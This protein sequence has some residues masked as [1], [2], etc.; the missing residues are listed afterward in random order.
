MALNTH[1]HIYSAC[2]YQQTLH[3]YMQMLA[4]TLF[5]SV[6]PVGQWSV[7]PQQGSSAHQTLEMY[8][9]CCVYQDHTN[10]KCDSVHI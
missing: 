2:T 6:Q 5:H 9:W 4:H 1:T 3:T 10:G 7:G 8:D